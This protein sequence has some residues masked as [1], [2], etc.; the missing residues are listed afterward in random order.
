MSSLYG[1]P[2]KG[3]LLITAVGTL[4]KTWVVD[5]TPFYFKDGNLIWLKDIQC[6]PNYLDWVMNSADGQR[7]IMDSA[8]GSNQKAL[9]IVKLNEIKILFPNKE[10][11][12]KIANYFSNLEYIITLHQRK[13][14][15]LKK[16]K[17]SM[18]E[19]M[20]PQNG[21]KEPQ[22][23]F[24]GFNSTW[25]QCKLGNVAQEFKS[26]NYISA[27]DIEISGKYPVYGGN[28]LRG[29]TSTYNHDGEFALIGRQGAL[30]GNMN[31]SVGKAY[32][33]E[34]AVVV[35]ADVNNDTKFIYYMFEMMNLGQYSDQSAQPGLAVNKLVKL[36]NSFPK[37][38]EQV[39]IGVFLKSI[40]NIITLHQR[41]LEKLKKIKKAMLEKMFV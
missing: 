20:F 28:G 6:N 9:T 35:K 26:G 24:C 29:Y 30:C 14:N 33:T 19:K 23:R 7:K 17:K 18:L 1:S 8:I 15:N 39:N 12:A 31:Y 37:I 25:E 13:L 4:G 2:K 27:D 41:K 38:E 32:F 36:K 3:D 40:D 34:H 16:V 10:E 22:I 5:K 11:Q 21:E